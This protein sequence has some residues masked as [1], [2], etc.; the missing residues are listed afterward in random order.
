[1]TRP[2]VFHKKKKGILLLETLIA[3]MILAIIT[4]PWL[5]FLK[6]RS[7]SYT[8]KELNLFFQT[9]QIFT[10]T[11]NKKIDTTLIKRGTASFIITKTPIGNNINQL[12]VNCIKDGKTK[13]S[14]VG[15]VND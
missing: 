15:V 7:I 10:D 6:V 8:Q 1:M 5:N 2:P 4:I 11:L 14:L 9:K 12:Q 13:Y 3:L